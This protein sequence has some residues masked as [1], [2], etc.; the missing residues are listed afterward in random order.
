MRSAS[1]WLSAALSTSSLVGALD[2]SVSPR[3]ANWTVGQV[4]QTS[5]GPVSGHPASVNND[6]SE[7]LGIPYA[8]PPVGDLRWTAPQPFNGTAPING[9]S[10]VCVQILCLSLLRSLGYWEGLV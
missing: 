3:A 1:T 8:V 7:Y 10:F 6:V 9:T 4:V 5:S 2:V